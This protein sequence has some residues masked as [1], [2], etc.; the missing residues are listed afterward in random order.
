MTGKLPLI[1]ANQF[2]LG[3][4]VT[5][6]GPQQ[7]VFLEPGAHDQRGIKGVQLK[8]VMMNPVTRGRRRPAIAD[9]PKRVAAL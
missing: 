5:R 4:H 2:A 6:D 9:A 7:R 3:Q 1:G 8:V